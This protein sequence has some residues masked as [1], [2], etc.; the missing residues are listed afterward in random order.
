MR[1]GDEFS[2]RDN[3][4]VEVLSAGVYMPEKE[5]MSPFR[6]TIVIC[7]VRG[8]GVILGARERVRASK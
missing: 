7:C 1:E 4:N 2:A 6:P 5:R 3:V 8:L